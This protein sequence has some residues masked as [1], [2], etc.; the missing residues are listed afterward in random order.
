MNPLTLW[1]LGW[2]LIALTLSGVWLVQTRTRN[3]GIVDVFWPLSIGAAGVLYAMLAS[4]SGFAR[5][6]LALLAAAWSLRLGGYLAL[7]NLGQAEDARYAKLREQWGTQVN[8][9]MFVFFQ[10]QALAGAALSL[11]ML[12]AAG[13]A[14]SGD[15][16]ILIGVAV[17]ALGVLGEAAADAQL[18]RFKSDPANRGRVCKYGLWRYSRHPNYFFESVFWCAFPILAWGAPQAWLGFVGP[19]LITFFLLKFTGVPATEEHARRSRGAEYEDYLRTTSRFIP[20]L[21]KK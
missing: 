10:I 21:P 8:A 13:H 18:A 6:C 15:G 14:D 19:V 17:G 5:L 9:R 12:A 20:W 7:R 4:G 3:A 2:L 16:Q 11:S 1:L